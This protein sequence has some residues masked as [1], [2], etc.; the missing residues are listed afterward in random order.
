MLSP[1]DLND[2]D[3]QPA[4]DFEREEIAR[5]INDAASR[6]PVEL[7]RQAPADVGEASISTSK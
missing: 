4:D 5:F 6:R 2:P 7:G 1:Y 3:K